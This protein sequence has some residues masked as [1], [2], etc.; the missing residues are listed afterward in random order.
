MD[1]VEEVDKVDKVDEEDD[2]AGLRHRG[3]KAHTTTEAH[4]WERQTKRK[5]NMEAN[6]LRGCLPVLVTY[7]TG[8]Y[9][10]TK[11]KG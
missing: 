2:E 10:Y 11:G 9:R 8:L 7:R 4:S 3:T 5:G 6:S 1:K